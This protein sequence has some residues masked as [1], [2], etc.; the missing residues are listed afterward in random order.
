MTLDRARLDAL[1]LDPVQLLARVQMSPT[2][3]PSSSLTLTKQSVC[4]PLIVNGRM[5]GGER[6]HRAGCGV[7][8]GVGDRQQRRPQAGEIGMLAI[9]AIHRVVGPGVRADRSRSRRR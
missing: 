8:G 3:K 9:E 4:R 2:S 6:P 1:D 5:P 7:G